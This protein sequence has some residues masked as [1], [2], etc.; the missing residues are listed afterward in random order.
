MAKRLRLYEEKW[1]GLHATL[2]HWSASPSVIS[3]PVFESVQGIYDIT[4]ER[5]WAFVCHP[6][7]ECAQGPGGVQ[8][9]SIRS[10]MQCW[11]PD[12][13]NGKV[14]H[15]VVEGNREAV[16]EAE[17]AGVARILTRFSAEMR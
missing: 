6:L 15:N 7:H 13:F 12:I 9:K 4:G 10:E 17:A 14:L 8:P 1:D 5:V 3:W 11:N 2:S 16:M